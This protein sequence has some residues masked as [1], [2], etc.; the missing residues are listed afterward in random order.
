MKPTR[1]LNLPLSEEINY[2][3][4]RSIPLPERPLR[5]TRETLTVYLVGVLDS[6]LHLP[7]GFLLHL[8][9]P[10]GISHAGHSIAGTAL[11]S[12]LCASAMRLLLLCTF[13]LLAIQDS[14]ASGGIRPNELWVVVTTINPPTSSI[15]RAAFE[16]KWSMVIVGD[17]K[18]PK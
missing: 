1:K 5:S 18:S 3:N 8:R 17:R 16:G 13:A 12:A 2:D 10:E 9:F 4:S 14:L 15:I 7:R 6:G 11:V